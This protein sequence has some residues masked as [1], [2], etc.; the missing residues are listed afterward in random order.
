MKPSVIKEINESSKSPGVYLFLDEHGQ[1][2]YVGKAKSLKE[3][4]KS[5]ILS[6][7]FESKS[8][9][10]K[11]SQFVDPKLQ[12]L[13]SKI[14]GLE[15]IISS[16]ES[17]A[18][19]LESQLIKKYKPRYNIQLKDD[20][21]YPYIKID[22]KNNWPKFEIARKFKNDGALYFGP[23]MS[24]RYI[25][26]LSSV[27]DE[28]FL[29][30]KCSDITFKTA[31]RPC[32]NY[33]MH[34]CL[35]P[36]QAYIDKK[37]Y[38]G[39]VN[40]VI[41]LLKGKTHKLIKEMEKEMLLASDNMA[42]EDASRIRERIKILEILNLKQSI[43]D[44]NDKRDIDLITY[45]YFAN[46]HY[47][48]IAVL[49]AGVLTGMSNFELKGEGDKEQAL[50]RFIT[51]YYLKNIVPDLVII[52]FD[53]YE[54]G[55]QDF[56]K[57]KKKTLKAENK[58]QGNKN[59]LIKKMTSHI[60]GLRLIA[61]KNLEEFLNRKSGLKDRWKKASDE[62]LKVFFTKIETVECYDVSNIS[63]KHTVGVKIYFDK[64][65]AIKD[66]YRR[67]KMKAEYK[68]DDLLAMKELLKRRFSH[69]EEE[70]LPDLILIDGGRT[71][72]RAVGDIF[73]KLNVKKTILASIAKDKTRAKGLS[74]DKIYRFNN[75]TGLI[76][77]V[78]LSTDTLNIMKMI[79]DEAH[80]FAITYNRKIRQKL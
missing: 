44:P 68:G 62:L 57:E 30:R 61:E 73:I 1:V 32:I 2:I 74:Q 8:T 14:N 78:V 9:R 59:I 66:N 37:D 36:C 33:D 19:I 41:D 17:E 10:S 49:R 35:A 25:K 20:K 80:R 60:K 48:N 43:I 31:K 42:F 69:L 75:A 28:V 67:Y 38:L 23:Y 52:P 3:R 7:S 22:I 72:L 18:L 55:V 65:F 15:T 5:Y 63:G 29:L 40:A 34:K 46:S 56:L 50:A 16:T 21:N 47:F 39:I 26:Q 54:E 27:I 77:P 24:T 76:E 45:K 70:P 12:A 58:K 51:D 4:L 13:V 71:Q 53:F 79:R 11:S 64:G 6:K